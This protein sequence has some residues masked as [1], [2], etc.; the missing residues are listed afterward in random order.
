MNF[1]STIHR[2]VLT[3]QQQSTQNFKYH[4]RIIHTKWSVICCCLS[5]QFSLSQKFHK[6]IHI[7]EVQSTLC[8]QKTGH[9]YYGQ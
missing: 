8:P 4:V 1:I 7:V 6:V 3:Y 5:R 9:A 2:L